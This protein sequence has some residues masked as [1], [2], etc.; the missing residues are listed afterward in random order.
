MQAG[1]RPEYA[2]SEPECARA[3]RT[4]PGVGPSFHPEHAGERPECARAGRSAPGVRLRVRR[5]KVDFAPETLDN[6]NYN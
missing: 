2:R 3:D 4:A 5:G 6:V 1:V